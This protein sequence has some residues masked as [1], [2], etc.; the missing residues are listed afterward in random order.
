ML[1]IISILVLFTIVSCMPE[2]KTLNILNYK[3]KSKT[4]PPLET[5][6]SGRKAYAIMA[7]KHNTVH[8]V[9]YY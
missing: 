7:M 5:T 1:Y 2:C 3:T 4:K 6:I 9:Q 8:R